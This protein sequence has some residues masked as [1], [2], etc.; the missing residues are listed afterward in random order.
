MELHGLLSYTFYLF[1]IA[2]NFTPEFT[3]SKS[4]HHHINR[5][6]KLF[7]FGDSYVDTGNNPKSFASSWKPPYGVTFPGKP[8]GRY[9]DGRVFTD[10]LGMFYNPILVI[11]VRGGPML[12]AGWTDAPLKKLVYFLKRKTDDT[13]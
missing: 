10:Y 12:M 13:P 9:S 5:P 8:A 11:K 7:V 4:I 6:T 2:G 3:I 1:L